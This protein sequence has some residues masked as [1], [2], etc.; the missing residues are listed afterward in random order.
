M[1]LLGVKEGSGVKRTWDLPGTPVV[2]H[3]LEPVHMQNTLS[4]IW[5]NLRSKCTPKLPLEL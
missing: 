1:A 3:N 2:G 5:H 4:Q